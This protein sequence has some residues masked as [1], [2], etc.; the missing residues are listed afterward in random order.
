M[1]ENSNFK[2]MRCGHEYEGPFKKNGGL[3]ERMCP[4]CS[5]NSIRRV[6]EK[7]AKK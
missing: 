5:S 6:R 4:E 3:V 1:E 2:C 7:K